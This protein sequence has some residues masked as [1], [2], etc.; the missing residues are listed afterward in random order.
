MKYLA[1]EDKA[2]KAA[3]RAR[4]AILNSTKEIESAVKKK[5]YNVEKPK[6]LFKPWSRKHLAHL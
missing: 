2:D 5:V 1:K 4:N 3:E 6:R